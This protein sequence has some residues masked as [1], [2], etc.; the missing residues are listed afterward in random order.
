MTTEC[1]KTACPY[2]GV[3]CGV[4]VDKGKIVGDDVHPANKGALC[5]KGSALAESLNMPSRLLYPKFNGKEI[6][7]DEATDVIAEA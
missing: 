5:V 6:S 1:I 2:C 3:G 4:K 7:W